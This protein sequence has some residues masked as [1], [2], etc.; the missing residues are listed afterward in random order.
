VPA[1]L[2]Q[3]PARSFAFG[4]FRLVPE[5]QLLTRADTPVAIGGRALD[6]LTLLVERAGEVVD[7]AELIA[8]AWPTTHVEEDNL[9]VTIAAL[10]RVLGDR[11]DAAQYIVTVIGQ[12]YRFAARVES[13]EAI[14]VVT[15]PPAPA[16]NNL[17]VS[18]SRIVG[19]DA[20]IDEIRR[21]LETDDRL[22]SIV[23][24]GGI[25]KTTVALAVA[26]QFI[27]RL[28]DGVWLVDLAPLTDASLVPNAI[29]TAIGLSAHSAGMLE[30]LCGYL[31]DRQL[32]IVLDNCEHVL[33][34][35]RA[36]VER[37]TAA[38]P[39][40]RILATSR[41]PLGAQGE[42]L[43]R[44]PGL[45]TP[46]PEL[47]PDAGEALAY[48]AV[49]L[50]VERASERLDGFS[51]TDADAPVVAEI[52]R[53][54]DGLALAIELAAT[55]VDAFGV[56]RL[57]QQLEGH[58]GAL[59][60]RRTGPQRHRTLQAVLDWSYGLLPEAEAAL[61]RCVS[62]FA[63]A[64]GLEAAAT[65]SDMDTSATRS[66][67]TQLAAKSLL[68]VE[69]AGDVTAY[70]LLETTHSY[71]A[72]MLVRSGRHNAVRQR[73]A[74]HVCD[75]L[76]QGQREWGKLSPR[77]WGVT[78]APLVDD[79][80]DALAW[81]AKDATHRELMIRLTV[82]GAVLWNH[83]SLT[84]ESL[85]HVSRALAELEPAGLDGGE[86]EMQLQIALA[87]AEMFTHGPTLAARRAMTRSLEIAE[88]L[89]N[90]DYRL[91]SL[92]MI[93][94]YEMFIGQNYAAVA[95]LEAFAT[96]AASED[97]GAVIDAEAHLC[98]AELLIGRFRTVRERLERHHL[99]DAEDHSNSPE[100]R[101][102]YDRNVDVGNV[103]SFAQ[104]LTGAPDSARRTAVTTVALAQRIRHGMSMSN[105]LAVAAC[106]VF[107][108]TGAHE[109]LAGYLDQLDDRLARDRN[110]IWRPV[111]MF[112]RGAMACAGAEVPAD[113][114]D[115]L[116]RAL[117][118]FEAQRHLTRMPFVLGTLADALSRSGHS[119]RAIATIDRALERAEDT[120]D[121]WSM[122][123][124]L[125]IRAAV[126]SRGS[127]TTEV[128]A[129]LERSMAMAR[130]MGALS[131]ELRSATDLAALW[132]ER[133]PDQAFALLSQ[134]YGRF[135][136][137]FGTRDLQAAASRLAAL[138]RK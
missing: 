45:A 67:L 58:F 66:A 8:R 131:W 5:R 36:T 72:Q 88:R 135:T 133:Q 113:G 69:P 103:L 97:P 31:R 11:R 128:E 112:Y 110:V 122:P 18:S 41:E 22:V 104:W 50:F 138:V 10:R 1:K 93:G 87:G 56:T 84:E 75:R 98:L 37:I 95:A 70:R 3:R 86:V 89:G 68:T 61:L 76:E 60:M 107:Y 26:E 28:D 83:L 55:R 119:S 123:E 99:P 40:V 29:A 19:R 81:A 42:Q 77:Q 46:P 27:G 79:L 115:D 85:V 21:D 80:R 136:E 132:A 118:G 117:A 6:I 51:L 129:E 53:R 7:K 17:P 96:L 33:A 94:S 48:S 34:G 23:G 14:P 124:L 12:G 52:C 111:A 39:G 65:V 92:R 127:S 125:R 116:E 137:G 109:E 106:P 9:K 20:L 47:V 63:G 114:L 101:F 24:A 32:L 74:N 4:P 62:V 130:D 100:V 15:D 121:K 43:R 2:E 120:G 73:H 59:G 49:Q 44:L 108:L 16:G 57:L 35:V 78:Y 54:L 25:G 102:L 134:V 13:L 105:A 38:V 126:I 71:A 64:F 91:R 30:A 82:A 90:T